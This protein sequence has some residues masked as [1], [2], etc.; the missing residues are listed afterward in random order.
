MLSTV[1][2]YIGLETVAACM[3]E[4]SNKVEGNASMKQV[5]RNKVKLRMKHVRRGKAAHNKTGKK[6]KDSVGKWDMYQMYEEEKFVTVVVVAVHCWH[7]GL[8]FWM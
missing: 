7:P 4:W 8:T 1:I 3:E 2:V 5:S 6:G